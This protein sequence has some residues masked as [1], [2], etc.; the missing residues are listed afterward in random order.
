MKND[1]FNMEKGRKAIK[2]IG[3]V[4]C[5]V[6]I[7]F[8]SF[9]IWQHVLVGKVKA[10][11]M[12]RDYI[13]AYDVMQGVID[14]SS[15]D[16]LPDK[17]NLL[18]TL[19]SNYEDAMKKLNQDAELSITGLPGDGI[20]GLIE[21]LILS[22]QQIDKA[23]EYGITEELLQV[24]TK[25]VLQLRVSNVGVY[26]ALRNTLYYNENAFYPI[27]DTRRLQKIFADTHNLVSTEEIEKV[28]NEKKALQ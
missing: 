26:G 6:F 11:Y 17:I 16:D 20:T 23:E 2:V 3:V 21:T 8:V 15:L 13:K 1:A 19:H 18:G 9:T 14:Q 12:D 27:T 25:I 10:L 24:Q 22:V 4:L 5:S 7:V 28:Q